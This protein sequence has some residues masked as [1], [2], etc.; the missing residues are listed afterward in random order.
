LVVPFV[1]RPTVD[2]PAVYRAMFDQATDARFVLDGHHHILHAN[3]AAALLFGAHELALRGVV[4][5][6]LL[7]PGAR[8]GFVH[9]LTSIRSPPGRFGPMPLEGRFSDGSAF[10]IEVDVVHGAEDR[11]GVVVRRS[12]R[13]ASA[14]AG[15]FNPGQVLIASR[16]KELV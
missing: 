1:R 12:S 16:I 14:P 13:T 15:R 11:Y 4:F 2:D 9:G 7:T 10:P 3:P 6:E 5:T 8:P